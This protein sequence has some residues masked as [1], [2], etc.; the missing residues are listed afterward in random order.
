MRTIQVSPEAALRIIRDN[1]NNAAPEIAKAMQAIKASYDPEV[2]KKNGGHIT[3]HRNLVGEL[4]DALTLILDLT[5]G[6]FQ[7][8]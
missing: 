1:C 6:K 4:C 7:M 5:D 2:D 8:G 3:L